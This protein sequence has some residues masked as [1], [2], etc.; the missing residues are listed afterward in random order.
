[1]FNPN[2]RSLLALDWG[3]RGSKLNLKVE[4]KAPPTFKTEVTFLRDNYLALKAKTSDIF[5]YY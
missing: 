1:M 2:W 4:L 3:A 5:I